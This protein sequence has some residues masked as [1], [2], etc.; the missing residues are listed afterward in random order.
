M[1][2][3]RPTLPKQTSIVLEKQTDG[4]GPCPAAGRGLYEMEAGFHRYWRRRRVR[5]QILYAS[6]ATVLT[7]SLLMVGLAGHGVLS[8]RAE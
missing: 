6:T 3:P 8:L 5:G 1:P 2:A 7:S 4:H